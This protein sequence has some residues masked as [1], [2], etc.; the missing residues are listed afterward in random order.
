[1]QDFSRAFGILCHHERRGSWFFDED[2]H[3]L[4][5]I[6]GR[7][8]RRRGAQAQG[9]SSCFERIIQNGGELAALVGFP[10]EEQQAILDI[11]ASAK[12][13]GAWIEIAVLGTAAVVLAPA[14]EEWLFRGLMFRRLLQVSGRPEAYVL[15]S[16]LFAAMHL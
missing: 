3:F 15:S 16:V 10:V 8:V 14:A 11:I 5:A 7:A 9:R 4:T 1:M 12:D 6:G 13:R 2:R